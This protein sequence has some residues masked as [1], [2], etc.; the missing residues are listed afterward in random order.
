MSFGTRTSDPLRNVLDPSF[1]PINIRRL[2]L[3]QLQF[4]FLVVHN[5]FVYRWLVILARIVLDLWIDP[6]EHPHLLN[7]DAALVCW[8]FL[9]WLVCRLLFRH[10]EHFLWFRRPSRNYLRAVFV[11]ISVIIVPNIAIQVTIICLSTKIEIE[12]SRSWTV[13]IAVIGLLL[14][15][16]FFTLIFKMA[17]K[18]LLVDQDDQYE[19]TIA[20][21]NM[22][23]SERYTDQETSTSSS[24]SPLLPGILSAAYMNQT[25]SST[26]PTSYQHPSTSTQ[27]LQAPE[28]LAEETV[29][30]VDEQDNS[31]TIAPVDNAIM[32]NPTYSTPGCHSL[33]YFEFMPQSRKGAG[34]WISFPIIPAFFG[35]YS[36]I[37]LGLMISLLHEDNKYPSIKSP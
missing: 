4:Q 33:A 21:E 29:T 18:Y 13:A 35:L 36:T 31:I 2:Y 23:N 19:P 12:L 3:H 15:I 27:I 16:P 30:I 24:S 10:P 25:F 22:A 37:T 28:S 20:R 17:Q 34:A 9:A 5:G 32:T 14:T 6:G 7:L 11:A 26:C 1:Y 8:E